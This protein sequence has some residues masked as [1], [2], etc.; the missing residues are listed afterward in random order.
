MGSRGASTAPPQPDHRCT[1]NGGFEALLADHVSPQTPPSGFDVERVER[2]LDGAGVA[3]DIAY[4]I[5]E[6]PRWTPA[7]S[8]R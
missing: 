8:R 1:L 5:V 7:R 2:L 3:L 6:R 4:R